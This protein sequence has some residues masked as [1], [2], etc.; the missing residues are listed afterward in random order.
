MKKFRFAPPYK[1][2]GKTSFPKSQNRP[3]VYIIKENGKIVYIGYSGS[4]LYKTMYRHFQAW[5]DATQRR[6]EY[7]PK[8][9][10]KYSVRIIYCTKSQAP[11]LEKMLI[12]KIG[13]RDND[14]KY[15]SYQ[16]TKWDH[17]VEEDFWEIRTETK[18]PF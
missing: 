3:G 17:N 4:N 5:R 14:E 18:A 15:N 10:K 9:R 16:P 11:R 1:K 8:G 12:K 6:V 7:N 13:P 2:D